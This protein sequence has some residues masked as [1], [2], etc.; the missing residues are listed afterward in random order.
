MHF[1]RVERRRRKKN[2]ENP[3]FIFFLNRMHVN[4]FESV[5]LFV[6]VLDVYM[7][8]FLFL[9]ILLLSFE[10]LQDY[11]NL[12]HSCRKISKKNLPTR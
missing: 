12:Q 8:V 4:V 10:V 7:D 9:F 3:I 1:E 2:K 5:L 11:K 6:M